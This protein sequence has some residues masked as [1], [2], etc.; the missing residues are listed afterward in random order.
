MEWGQS[1][2]CRGR[3]P[4]RR[5]AE[6]GAG[7]GGRSWRSSS[8]LR[9]GRRRPGAER[10]QQVVE[11]LEGIARRPGDLSPRR[12]SRGPR[13]GPAQSLPRAGGPETKP[14]RPPF[15]ALASGAGHSLR[16][17][18]TPTVTASWLRAFSCSRTGPGAPPSRPASLS[19]E[20]LP[21]RDETE[22]SFDPSLERVV[23]RRRQRYL[24][25]IL[26]STP[27]RSLATIRGS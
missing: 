15:Q 18:P 20:T 19:I 11:Q 17:R 23:A 4:R 7:A 1:L 9:R 21:W 25:L 5:A 26:G 6:R 2:G 3:P 8:R 13:R 14:S 27:S 10:V 16:G 22:L 12:A 24:G